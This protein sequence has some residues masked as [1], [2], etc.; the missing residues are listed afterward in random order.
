MLSAWII[1]P[2]FS[3]SSAMNL[4]KSLGVID[5]GAA[6]LGEP[7]RYHGIGESRINLFV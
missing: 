3:V 4:P 2:H 7:R 1:L 5:F 6:Y